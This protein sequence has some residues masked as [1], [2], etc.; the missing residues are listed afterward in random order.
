MHAFTRPSSQPR[1]KVRD[2]LLRSL[3]HYSSLYRHL[4][5]ANKEKGARTKT[6]GKVLH[7]KLTNWEGTPL[8]KFIYGQF[9]N[10]KLA[11]R[12]G[13]ALTNECPLCHMPYSCTHIAGICLDHEALRIN[14]QNVACQFIH[15]AIRKTAKGE[16]PSIARRT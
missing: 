7:E 14:R 6:V 2:A 8:L 12:Y 3:H 9:Y 4:I 5:I 13:H 15:A 10:G 16:G 11:K 1:L